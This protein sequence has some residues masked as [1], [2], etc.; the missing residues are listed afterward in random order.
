MKPKQN[1]VTLE[2][3]AAMVQRGFEKTATK[4]AL[5]TAR[6]EFSGDIDSLRSE[7]RQGFSEVNGRLDRLD[8]L[9]RAVADVEMELHDLKKRVERLEKQRGVPR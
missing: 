5:D 7:L 1:K 3:L 6:S 4:E 9:P 2:V 8:H